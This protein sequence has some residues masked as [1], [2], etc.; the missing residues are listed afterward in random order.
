VGVSCARNLQSGEPFPKD[1]SGF[2]AIPIHVGH[3]GVRTELCDDLLARAGPDRSVWA[4]VFMPGQ[5]DPCCTPSIRLSNAQIRVLANGG[6]VVSFTLASAL[7]V[8]G[9]LD[10]GDNPVVLRRED[11]PG[12]F[13]EL[14]DVR[15]N[16]FAFSADG[17]YHQVDNL[18]SFRVLY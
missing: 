7:T 13:S 15:S 10:H 5:P 1:H 9:C 14:N 4:C 12:R 18:I 3:A 8:L 16:E 2:E 17:R 6:L 11:F